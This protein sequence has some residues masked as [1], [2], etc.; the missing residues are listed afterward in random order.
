MYGVGPVTDF[1]KRC[2]GTP[3]KDIIISIMTC[4]PR[5]VIDKLHAALRDGCSHSSLLSLVVEIDENYPLEPESDP[6]T[7]HSLRLLFCFANL[8]SVF[9]TSLGFDMDD[10]G[11]DELACAWPQL[12]VLRLRFAGMNDPTELEPR[13]SLRSL[14]TLA[15]HCRGLTELE[16][17]LNATVVPEPDLDVVP[18][19]VL[20]D[21]N[22][23]RSPIASPS[24]SI[25]QFIATIFPNVV[26]IKT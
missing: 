25:T 26:E 23:G 22:V 3:L 9:I 11:M 5:A 2:S 7:I 24:L 20:R 16:F 15:K 8:T 21:F 10:Q 4:P 6:M 18:Q 19:L 13:F 17:T 14:S 1:F 12:R